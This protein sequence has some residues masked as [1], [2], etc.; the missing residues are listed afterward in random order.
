MAVVGYLLYGNGVLDELS[1]NMI[2][3]KGYPEAVKVLVLI[4]VAVIPITKFPLQ[5]VSNNRCRHYT[6]LTIATVLHQSSPRWRST[7]VS[8]L[9]LRC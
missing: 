5:S 3:T 8:I 6:T 9:A 7:L 4:L 2:K 1:T